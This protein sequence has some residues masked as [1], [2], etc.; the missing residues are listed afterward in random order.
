[1]QQKVY[2]MQQN[3]HLSTGIV[4]WLLQSAQSDLHLGGQEKLY[5]PPDEVYKYIPGQWDK[6][7]VIS[8]GK[9]QCLSEAKKVPRAK[10]YSRSYLMLAYTM[11][12]LF[13]SEARQLTQQESRTSKHK[14]ETQ[15]NGNAAM[16]EDQF[17]AP[18]AATASE[19]RQKH[20]SYA[21][22]QPT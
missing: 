3:R 7:P 13:C 11:L 21:H 22:I 5:S 8:R 2:Y 19:Y 18:E 4:P 16:K 12:R 1:M 14:N 20:S 6:W 10:V 9:G 15:H 17:Q